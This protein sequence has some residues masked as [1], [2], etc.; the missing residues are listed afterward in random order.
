MM[1]AGGPIVASDRTDTGRQSLHNKTFTVFAVCIMDSLTSL[2]DSEDSD[3]AVWMS[4]LLCYYGCTSS[5]VG[6]V[7]PG[8]ATITHCGPTHGTVRKRHGSL[9]LLPHTAGT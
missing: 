5:F 1:F 3:Q 2:K 9:T 8:D 7:S 6:F 4:L